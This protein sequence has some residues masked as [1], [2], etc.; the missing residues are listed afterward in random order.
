MFNHKTIRVLANQDLGEWKCARVGES[1]G[2]R[3]KEREMGWFFVP[4]IVSGCIGMIPRT[5]RVQEC[6]YN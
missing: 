5:P 1:G 2:I 6:P 3:D 4:D